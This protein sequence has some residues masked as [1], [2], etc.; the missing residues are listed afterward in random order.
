MPGKEASKALM[1]LQSTTDTGPEW[2]SLGQ[3]L[4]WALVELGE[5]EYTIDHS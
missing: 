1:N 2:S 3:Q 4:D 5:Y